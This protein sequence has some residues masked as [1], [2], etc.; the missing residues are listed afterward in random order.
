[1]KVQCLDRKSHV[2][3]ANM[4]LKMPY[5]RK[6]ALKTRDIRQLMLITVYIILDNTDSTCNRIKTSS[7]CVAAAH[8]TGLSVI[9]AMDDGQN[10][11][12]YDPPYCYFEGGSLKFN[13]H[14]TNSGPCSTTDK[15]L[16]LRSGV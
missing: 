9:A 3:S 5:V 14:G 11:V 1:M 15:C 16:C 7:E 6:F 12:S 10:G 2:D 4:Y 13:L 8:Q